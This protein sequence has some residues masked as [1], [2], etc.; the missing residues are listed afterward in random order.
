VI[1]RPAV[2]FGTSVS[3]PVVDD[4]GLVCERNAAVADRQ[5]SALLTCALIV[6]MIVFLR[7]N[8]DDGG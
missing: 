2:I 4:V 1:K 6:V 7:A 5:S 8:H 3:L